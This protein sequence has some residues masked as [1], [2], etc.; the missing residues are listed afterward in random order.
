MKGKSVSRPRRRRR[1]RFQPTTVRTIRAERRRVRVR[2]LLI[3]SRLK[4]HMPGCVMF[5]K[6]VRPRG[7]EEGGRP[8]NSRRGR[9]LDKVSSSSSTPPKNL[10]PPPSPRAAPSPPRG[11]DGKESLPLLLP[12]DKSLSPPTDRDRSISAAWA[13]TRPRRSSASPSGATDASRRSLSRR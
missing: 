3:F 4:S 5:G 13:R 2:V 6:G 1:A 9:H 11:R 12:R 10:R 7:R 8:R